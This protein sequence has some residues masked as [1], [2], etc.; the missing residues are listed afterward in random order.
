[1]DLLQRP[2]LFRDMSDTDRSDWL[3]QRYAV[4]IHPMNLE[5][6]IAPTKRIVLAALKE[7]SHAAEF[8]PKD[9]RGDPD[10]IEAVLKHGDNSASRYLTWSQ[11]TSLEKD[12]RWFANDYHIEWLKRYE[13]DTGETV[14]NTA[15]WEM[16]FKSRLP[17]G[18]HPHIQAL[19]R[20]NYRHD[21]TVP[22]DH[23]FMP[24]IF[25]SL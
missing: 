23:F 22:D 6:C 11:H 12:P 17:G 16:C 25:Y 9:M 19:L 20:E 13:Q 14:F 4:L 18:R 24:H 10:I 7:T 2:E 21:T 15:D 1:M 8:I 5:H 3:T